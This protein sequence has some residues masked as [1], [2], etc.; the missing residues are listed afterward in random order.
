VVVDE[1]HARQ[2]LDGLPAGCAATIESVNL[3]ATLSE[4][5]Q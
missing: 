3:E 2:V 1:Q 5:M 4:W